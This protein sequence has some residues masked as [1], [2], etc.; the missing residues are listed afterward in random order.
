[1]FPLLWR[2]CGYPKSQRTRQQARKPR[3]HCEELEPRV[4]LSVFTFSTGAPDGKIATISEPASAHTSKVEYESADDFALD[5]ET[6]I[7]KAS[8]TGLLTGGVT[9]KDV[10]SVDVEIYRVFPFDS[11]VGRT[12]GPPTFSTSK[13][14]TRVNS[15]SDNAFDTRESHQLKFKTLV[16]SPTFAAANSVSSA[17]KISV[18]SGGNGPVTGEEVQFNVTFKKPFDLPAGHYFFVPQVGLSDKA[19]SGGDFL[20][21][22]APRPIVPPGTPF[23]AGV[24]DLQSWMRDDPP[25]APDW[26]RIGTDIVGG[27]MTFN[28]SF[29]LSGQ[30][31]KP[32]IT[33]LSPTSVVEGSPDLTI[34][35][36]GNN[37]TTHSTVLVNGKQPLTTTFVS[38]NQL[39]ATIPAAL[40]AE[41]GHLKLSVE[42]TENGRSNAKKF[43]ITESI[44][45]LTASVKQ[46]Q[47]AQ[48]FTVS[49]QVTDQVTE[50]H[51][52]RIRWGDGTED[53]V[54]L[55][56]GTGGPFSV[57]HTYA[58]SK[59]PHHKTIVVS[60][61]DD[62][63][64]P[65][66]SQKFDIIV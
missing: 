38:A 12:S 24:T 58:P 7:E 41:D 64:A 16:L 36:N 28:A 54:D 25:L 43:T 39:K 63:D 19:P 1:M 9:P 65:V 66:A 4:Q 29:S 42:D 33:S 10:K 47:T 30:T 51:R 48:Q 13:V 3:L 55:G 15:P 61:L 56:V 46:G 11:D 50:D 40:L 62:K 5:T 18:A 52:V 57:S 31:V 34:T 37:F 20:W 60:V 27:G 22:S 53:V 2:Y 59:H 21:L 32:K 26:L 23:P 45:T 17:S 49:G 44:P 6:R 8:F 14:P 35:I